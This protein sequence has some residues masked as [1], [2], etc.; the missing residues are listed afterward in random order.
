M[1]MNIAGRR[2]WEQS[3]DCFNKFL[4]LSNACQQEGSYIKNKPEYHAYLKQMLLVRQVEWMVVITKIS[5]S[6][7]LWI[8]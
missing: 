4:W 2:R 3:R 7:S 8:I 5:D 1:A 6:I